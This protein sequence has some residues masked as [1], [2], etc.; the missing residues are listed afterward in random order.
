MNSGNPTRHLFDPRR[1]LPSALEIAWGAPQEATLSNVK[2]KVAETTGAWSMVDMDDSDVPGR[3]ALL[4][5]PNGTLSGISVH[6]FESRDFWDG[7]YDYEDMEAIDEEYFGH[8]MVVERFVTDLL[9]PP[10]FRGDWETEGIEE[11]MLGPADEVAYWDHPE[12]RIQLEYS[13]ED[14]E[15]PFCVDLHLVPP[16]TA[17]GR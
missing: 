10:S 12:A 13:H 5:H 2:G 6:L 9:G 3:V 16:A 8:F 14:K 17:K 11:A 7:D 1:V 4:F 15:L